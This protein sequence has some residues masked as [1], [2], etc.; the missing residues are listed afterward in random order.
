LGNTG[1]QSPWDAES[2]HWLTLTNI[3]GTIVSHR[4]H[5]EQAPVT[6][7]GDWCLLG[8]A[9]IWLTQ[10]PSGVGKCLPME[11]MIAKLMMLAKDSADYLAIP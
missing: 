6:L 1:V 7:K 10:Y 9:M 2:F 5:P 3:L 11:K 4:S 8:V